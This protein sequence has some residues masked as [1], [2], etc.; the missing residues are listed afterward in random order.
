MWTDQDISLTLF[1]FKHSEVCIF[2]SFSEIEIFIDKS[3]IFF[4]FDHTKP[5]KIFDE[6]TL[7]ITLSRKIMQ[8][9]E[10]SEI[11]I[12]WLDAFV[13]KSVDELIDV[14]VGDV[15]GVHYG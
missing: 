14:A 9:I 1:I 2:I 5:N 10:A 8:L 7:D 4:E 3:L 11:K 6:L 15:C 13:V 12:R